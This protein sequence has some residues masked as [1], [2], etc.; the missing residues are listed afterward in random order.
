MK[1]CMYPYYEGADF[2]SDIRFQKFWAKTSKFRLFG[3]KDFNFLILMKFCLY[4]VSKVLILKKH[5][6]SKI[7]NPNHNQRILGKFCYGAVSSLK[8][9]FYNKFKEIE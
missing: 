9:L 3:T 2:K 8:L 4:P 6:F 5:L 7:S 1:F